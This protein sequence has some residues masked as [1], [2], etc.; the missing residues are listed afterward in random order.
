MKPVKTSKTLNRRQFSGLALS[1]VMPLVAELAGPGPARGAEPGRHA[2]PQSQEEADLPSAASRFQRIH[3]GIWKATFG[4]PEKFSPVKLRFRKPAESA[5]RKL[6]APSQCPLA[7]ARIRGEK[8]DRGYVV[9]IPLPVGEQ[10]YGF[11]LQFLSFEQRKG[12]KIV[13]TNADP[14][15]NSGDTN[16]PVP[17]YVTTGGYGVFIDSS[18]YVSFYIGRESRRDAAREKLTGTQPS[19]MGKPSQQLLLQAYFREGLGEPS[20]VIAEIPLQAGADIYIFG[21]PTMRQAVERYNLFSGGGCL[22]PR[23]GLGFW[24]RC[25]SKYDQKQVQNLA[26]EFR[27]SRMPGDAIG[28][29]P[30]WQT[31]AYSC[32]FVWNPDRFPDPAGM[33]RTLAGQGFHLNLWEHAFTHPSSP[34]HESLRPLAGNYDVWEGL[35]PDFLKPEARKIFADFHEKEHVRIGVSGYKLDECDNSDFTGG[36]SFPEFSRFPSGLDGEQMHSHF[37]PAYQET[38]ESIF[39][40]RNTRSYQL[41]RS[42]NALAAPFPFVLYS[43]LY[44]HRNYIRALANS[45][46][47]GLLWS[48]EVRNANDE[49][50]LIRRLQTACFSALMQINAWYLKNPPWKQVNREANNAGQ[51]APDWRKLEA[52]CREILRLRM[53][54]VPYLYSAFVRYHEQGTPPFRALVMDY[55]SDLRTWKI[56]DQYLVGESVMVAPVVAG[57]SRR[58]IYLPQGDW[59]DFWSGKG[60]PGGQTITIDV[61][62]NVI[63]LFVKAGTVLPLA[64]PSLHAGE[65]AARQLTVKVY[66]EGNRAFT[67][68]EDDD[69]S[70][71]ALRGKY[72]R[73]VLTWDCTAK[74]GHAERIGHGKYPRY[75]ITGWEPV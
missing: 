75:E 6:P 50:D 57:E 40:R 56:D 53:Q 35:V 22:P 9:K 46:F 31:H 24:Y 13:R 60:L 48:P 42:S 72:N 39:T 11:G 23:W 27:R 36:W 25:D 58:E 64:H 74:K 15:V 51:L 66:G 34:I 19:G 10:V 38:I 33:I 47:S 2:S 62:L 73:V 28:L 29:E 37:G 32:S 69:R 54:F 45:G 3:P 59:V 26:G 21:G 68:Y 65:P 5:L 67:L 70:L 43:D 20:E 1:S 49:E 41:V 44:D 17:F 52:Q 4:V 61:P 71:E 18:R 8:T 14:R 7:A 55:P 63:P 12:K 16:A 30:G